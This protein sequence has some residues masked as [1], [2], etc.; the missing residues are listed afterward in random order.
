MSIKTFGANSAVNSSS[1]LTTVI[2]SLATVNTTTNVIL[3]YQNLLPV[4]KY[5]SEIVAVAD[6]LQD[7]EIFGIDCTHF[8]TDS[9]GATFLVKFRYFHPKDIEMLSKTLASYGLSGTLESALVGLREVVDIEPRPNS[10][11]Y[12]FIA[13]HIN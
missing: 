1:L 5:D 3:P 2:S 4:G 8:L 7:N 11:K 10:I 9:S 13:S 12:V 6:A